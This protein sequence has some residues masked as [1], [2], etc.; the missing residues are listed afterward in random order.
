MVSVEDLKKELRDQ[1]ELTELLQQEVGQHE[2]E[3]RK[4]ISPPVSHLSTRPDDEFW[5]R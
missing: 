3:K 5:D 4:V 1:K 2:T